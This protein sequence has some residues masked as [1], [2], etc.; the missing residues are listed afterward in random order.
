MERKPFTQSVRFL[1]KR[2]EVFL[3][4][5]TGK[6]RDNFNFFHVR[7]TNRNF[8]FICTY[9]TDF[10]NFAGTLQQDFN[11]PHSKLWLRYVAGRTSL[12]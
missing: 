2:S 3:D 1:S 9:L 11:L 10:S 8:L 4:T 7:L 12:Y 5:N 6:F